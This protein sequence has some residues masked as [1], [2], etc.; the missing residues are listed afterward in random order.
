MLL[1]SLGRHDACLKQICG[2]RSPRGFATAS[3][4][5]AGPQASVDQALGDQDDYPDQDSLRCRAHSRFHFHGA[6]SSQGA[7]DAK[8]RVGGDASLGEQSREEGVGVLRAKSRSLR[9]GRRLVASGRILTAVALLLRKDREGSRFLLDG[10]VF[11]DAFDA[12]WSEISNNFRNDPVDK[13]RPP[14]GL[15]VALFRR[16]PG[17]GWRLKQPRLNGGNPPQEPSQQCAKSDR[18]SCGE[19]YAR[20]AKA[21]TRRPFLVRLPFRG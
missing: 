16:S 15:R 5:I 4:S 20:F 2:Y 21:C 18:V 7:C 6:R 19:G 11:G 1:N 17:A 12:A 13:R 14:R 10:L 9:G 8:S 3:P